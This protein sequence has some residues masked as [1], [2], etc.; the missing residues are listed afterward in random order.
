[1]SGSLYSGHYQIYL[2]LFWAQYSR[3]CGFDP[4]FWQ[5]S[6]LEVGHKIHHLPTTYSSRAVVSLIVAKGCALSI[7]LPLE[8]LSLPR[9]SM[10]RLTDWHLDMTIVVDTHRKGN[11]KKK[12]KKKN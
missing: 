7:S 11:N 10:A 1:M 2:Y 3:G 9:K 12:K 5:I 6:L 4:L 8:G